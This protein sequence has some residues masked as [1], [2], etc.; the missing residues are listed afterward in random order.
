M[1]AKK[2]QPSTPQATTP[3]PAQTRTLSAACRRTPRDPFA[4]TAPVDQTYRYR[5]TDM[6]YVQLSSTDLCREILGD[7]DEL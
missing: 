4:I 5:H 3:T 1:P 6:P 7:M 2:R